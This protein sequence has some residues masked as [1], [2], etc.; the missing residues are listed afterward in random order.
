MLSAIIA[1]S[2][3]QLY[4][5]YTNH[6]KYQYIDSP[7]LKTFCNYAAFGEFHVN[8]VKNILFAMFT[9]GPVNSCVG[10]AVTN[11]H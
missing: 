5:N 1:I 2:I 4:Q 7:W 6:E 11:W 3:L 10:H 9:T 8:L